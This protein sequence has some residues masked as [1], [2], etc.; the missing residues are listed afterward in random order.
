MY[1]YSED[2]KGQSHLGHVQISHQ[3]MNIFMEAMCDNVC[4]MA[5]NIHGVIPSKDH[6]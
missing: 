1:I 2:F 4:V 5:H 3:I 6:Q